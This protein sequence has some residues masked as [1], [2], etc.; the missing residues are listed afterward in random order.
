MGN[1]KT[2][3]TLPLKKLRIN[4]KRVRGHSISI[5][6]QTRG[7]LKNIIKEDPVEIERKLRR[8]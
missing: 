3:K 4:E 8:D 5:F 7:M 1:I 2:K 6:E